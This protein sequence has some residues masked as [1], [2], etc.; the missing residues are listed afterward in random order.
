MSIAV[1]VPLQ[2]RVGHV[3]GGHVS[4][5]NNTRQQVDV[6]ATDFPPLSLEQN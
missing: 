6:S 3:N 1:C 4:E 2:F 5:V